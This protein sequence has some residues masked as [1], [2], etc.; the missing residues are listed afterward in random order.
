MVVNTLNSPWFLDDM[1][2]LMGEIGDRLDVVMVP[3]GEGD[4]DIHFVDHYLALLEARHG[5]KKPRDPRDRAG[6]QQCRFDRG[7]VSAHA[8]PGRSAIGF[9]GRLRPPTN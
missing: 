7:G 1:T 5:L 6:R 3:K 4:W 9:S 2:R 8:N